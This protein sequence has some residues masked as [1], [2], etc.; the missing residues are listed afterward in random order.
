MVDMRVQFISNGHRGESKQTSGSR[1]YAG[2]KVNSLTQLVYIGNANLTTNKPVDSKVVVSV[3]TSISG[4]GD[5][6][7]DTLPPPIHDF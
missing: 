3:E 1:V 7:R 5:R 4:K 2:H 6:T